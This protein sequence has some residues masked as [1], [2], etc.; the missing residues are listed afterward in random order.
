MARLT[1]SGS[2]VCTGARGTQAGVGATWHLQHRIIS[3]QGTSSL[4]ILLR[5]WGQ[6]RSSRFI[7][8]R[9][10]YHSTVVLQA[11]EL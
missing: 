10:K 4:E 5:G 7:S 8:Q 3:F 1:D 11:L 9:Y 2:A 6:G